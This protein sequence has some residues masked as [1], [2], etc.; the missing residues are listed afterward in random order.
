M[1]PAV[2]TAYTPSQPYATNRLPDGP[3]YVVPPPDLQY[4]GGKAIFTFT[5]SA[6]LL[7]ASAEFGNP[8]FLR[9]LVGTGSLQIRHQALDWKY[10]Q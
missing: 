9:A 2:Q 8:A 3:R 6:P 7:N 4:G 1:S 10:E 5:G